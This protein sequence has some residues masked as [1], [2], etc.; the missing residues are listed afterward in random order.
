MRNIQFEGST[1]FHLEEA[2]MDSRECPKYEESNGRVSVRYCVISGFRVLLII[3]IRMRK[4]ITVTSLLKRTRFFPIEC[5]AGDD[6]EKNFTICYH[7]REEDGL[8]V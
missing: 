5:V 7:D 2:A 8:F 4:F 3:V 1:K 6:F